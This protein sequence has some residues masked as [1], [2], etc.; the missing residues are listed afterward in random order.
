MTDGLPPCLTRRR[1][2]T[3]AATVG[4]GVPLLA[5]CSGGDATAK[6]TGSSSGGALSSTSDIEVGGGT[7]WD[8][9]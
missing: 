9:A 3:G 6:D 5:A 1:A 8:L 4:I 7:M 2:L